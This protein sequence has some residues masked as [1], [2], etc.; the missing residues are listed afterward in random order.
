MSAERFRQILDRRGL[1]GVDV[2]NAVGVHKNTVTNWAN[3]HTPVIPETLQRLARVL[4]TSL[5]DLAGG[6]GPTGA[7]PL[8]EAETE[9]G[10]VEVLR[11]LLERAPALQ[12]IAE[13][14]PDLLE[15]LGDAEE[16]VR[17]FEA[18]MQSDGNSR[19][20]T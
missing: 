5:D 19:S 4:D 20:G 6:R 13:A 11:R 2:A 14:T 17:R 1:R 16:V 15:V 9:D 10:A 7:T 8:T 18:S 12:A 3:G